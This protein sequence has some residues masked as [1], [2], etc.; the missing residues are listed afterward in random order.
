[1]ISRLW[2]CS[3]IITRTW[4][5]IK[6]QVNCK[7]PN[8]R[9]ES[10]VGGNITAIFVH[11]VHQHGSWRARGVHCLFERANFSKW[12]WYSLT[13]FQ[14]SVCGFHIAISALF[15][16]T[17]SSSFRVHSL[18]CAHQPGPARGS[19]EKEPAVQERRW[20]VFRLGVSS[21]GAWESMSYMQCWWELNR[22]LNQHL[23][24]PVR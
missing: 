11:G 9:L 12:S 24:R 23:S 17:L 21:L 15:K 22:V 7:H 20:I 4:M 1:M 19:V 13:S 14:H 6:P 5:S 8:E 3:R 2:N 18:C 16:S 10:S